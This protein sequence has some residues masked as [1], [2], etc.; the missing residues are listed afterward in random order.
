VRDLV[1]G[2]WDE[3]GVFG[4]FELLGRGD[5]KH[6]VGEH[7]Q[8]GPPRPRRVAADLVLI[9]PCQTLSGLGTSTLEEYFAADPGRD[10][11]LRAVERRVGTGGHRPAGAVGEGTLRTVTRTGEWGAL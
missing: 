11:D 5:G 9:E 1:A 2:Q 8:H 10:A 6:G 3:V 4:Q 7:D